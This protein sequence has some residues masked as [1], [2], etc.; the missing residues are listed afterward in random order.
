M[1]TII[2]TSKLGPVKI[3]CHVIAY[4]NNQ[5]EHGD[6]AKSYM[7]VVS[8]LQSQQIEKLEVPAIIARRMLQNGDSPRGIEF[9]VHPD[10]SKVFLV[11]TKDSYRLVERAVLQCMDGFVFGE[12]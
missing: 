4:F 7:D 1:D 11:V 3:S 10:S 2:E 9:W 6:P 5:S 12:A 8:M